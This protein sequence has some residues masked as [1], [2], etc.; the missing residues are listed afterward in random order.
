MVPKPIHEASVKATD[1]LGEY[2]NIR[3]LGEKKLE[4]VIETKKQGAEK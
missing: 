1:R 2:R 3:G 4:R